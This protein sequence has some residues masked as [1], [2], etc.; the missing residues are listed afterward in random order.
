MTVR[1]RLDALSG[2][3]GR[4]YAVFRHAW[5]HRKAMGGGLFHAQEAEFLPA[6]LSLQ[7]RPVSATARLTAGPLWAKWTSLLTGWERWC[8]GSVPK[9]L[10]QWMWPVCAPCMSKK[11]SR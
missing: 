9:P 11:G 7:E 5:R 6:A 4:Y 3:L 8:P 10:L 1:Y 2:L